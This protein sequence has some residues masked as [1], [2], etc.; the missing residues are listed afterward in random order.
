[1][2][3]PTALWALWRA[4]R[5]KYPVAATNHHQTDQQADP[6]AEFKGDRP[7]IP[8]TRWGSCAAH[9]LFLFFR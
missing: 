8:P 5:E 1:M 2:F 6:K 9:E 7:V 3:I 4:P